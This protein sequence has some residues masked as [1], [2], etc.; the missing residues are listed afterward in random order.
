MENS[1]DESS[2]TIDFRRE[3]AVSRYRSTETDRTSFPYTI[4]IGI[5]QYIVSYKPR[6]S[7][8]LC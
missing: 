8:L 6:I 4:Q 7:S 5:P 3:I 2:S 1:E